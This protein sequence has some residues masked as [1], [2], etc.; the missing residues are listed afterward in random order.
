MAGEDWACRR[1]EP[2]P[3]LLALDSRSDSSGDTLK[4][5]G[6]CQDEDEEG[7]R[8]SICAPYLI[9]TVFRGLLDELCLGCTRFVQKPVRLAG[10]R[11]GTGTHLAI[12]VAIATSTNVA[13]ATSTNVAIATSTTSTNTAVKTFIVA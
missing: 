3:A 4:N 8:T 7:V 10:F 13:I 2:L 6:A 12:K 9:I 1:L 11:S 5:A